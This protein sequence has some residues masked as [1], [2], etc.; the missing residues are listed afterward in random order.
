MYKKVSRAKKDL[1]LANTGDDGS[2]KSV[3]DNLSNGENTQ[4]NDEAD[5]VCQLTQKQYELSNELS[6]GI[7]K[8]K[9]LIQE[10]EQCTCKAKG[11]YQD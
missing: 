3:S 4:K 7:E 10:T 8:L 9:K 6:G 1:P 2:K 11:K 5:I